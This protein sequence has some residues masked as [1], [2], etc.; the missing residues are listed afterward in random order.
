MKKIEKCG[1]W[2]VGCVVLLLLVL[3]VPMVGNAWPG[4]GGASS[5][6]VTENTADIANLGTVLVPTRESLSRIG[7]EDSIDIITIGQSQVGTYEITDIEDLNLPDWYFSKDDAGG[8]PYSYLAWSDSNALRI[9]GPMRQYYYTGGAVP[10]PYNRVGSQHYNTINLYGLTQK[11]INNLVIS[12]GGSPITD[13][14]KG[15][16]VYTNMLIAYSALTNGSTTAGQ[17]QYGVWDHGQSGGADYL[18]NLSNTLENIETDIGVVGM[19]WVLFGM[20]GSYTNSDAQA[21]IIQYASDNPTTTR[22]VDCSDLTTQADNVHYTGESQ[23]TRAARLTHAIMSFGADVSQGGLSVTGPIAGHELLSDNGVVGKTVVAT[24]SSDT[25][26]LTVGSGGAVINGEVAMHSI[27]YSKTSPHYIANGGFCINF[28]NPDTVYDPVNDVAYTATVPGSVAYDTNFNHRVF[29]GTGSVTNHID[30]GV[31]MRLDTYWSFAF[32]M[33]CPTNITQSQ[34]VFGWGADSGL[35]ASLY[36]DNVAGVWQMHQ[37]ASGSYIITTL[38]KAPGVLVK[39]GKWHRYVVT[40]ST[41]D[42]VMY[43][44]RVLVTPVATGGTP[45]FSPTSPRFQLIGATYSPSTDVGTESALSNIIYQKGYL[46]NQE[47]VNADYYY[48]KHGNF[49]VNGY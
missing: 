20:Q 12:K 14:L 18:L 45:A 15:T 40:G 19:K 49:N 23:R 10:L 37:A 31:D 4:G 43:V 8:C 28:D 9:N 7:D 33:K 2:K 17:I 46:M 42:V 41:Y 16:A 48:S 39:D 32:S 26:K 38:P 11:Y 22:F 27:P 30:L 5:T 6:Q 34:G 47:D 35:R 13:F 1:T 24:I 29:S 25:P 36:Y 44:D 21:A 3:A